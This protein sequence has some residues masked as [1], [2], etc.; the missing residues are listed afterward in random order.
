[1]SPYVNRESSI[2]NSCVLP[3]IVFQLK[4][5]KLSASKSQTNSIPSGYCCSEPAPET[6]VS[7][8]VSGKSLILRTSYDEIH[9]FSF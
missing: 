4:I 5:L 9:R 2:D 7:K 8:N 6:L 3:S 1:M